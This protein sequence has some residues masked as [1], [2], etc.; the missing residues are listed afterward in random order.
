MTEAAKEA[1]RAYQRE[2]A[3]KNPDKRQATQARYWAKKAKEGLTEK[4]VN[5]TQGE[6]GAM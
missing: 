2:W 5:A 1:R 4:D 3:K 6:T